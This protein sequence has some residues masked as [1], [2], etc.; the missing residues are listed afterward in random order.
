MNL[1]SYIQSWD[2]TIA[3]LFVNP[4]ITNFPMNLGIK[5]QN[6]FIPEPF[7]GD[8]NNCSLVIV[9]LNPGAGVCHSCFKQQ[10]IVGTLVNKVKSLGY[11]NA[12]KDFPYL[13]D[14]ETVGL[15]DWNDSPGRKWWKSK[16][17]W[18]KHMLNICVPSYD[19][20]YPIPDDYYPFAMEMFAWHTNSWPSKLNGKMKKDGSFG[21]TIESDVI[22]PLYEA[23]KKSKFKI[24]I[25]V[26]KPIG[27]I[28]GSFGTFN[29]I[30]SDKPINGNERQYDIYHDGDDCYII[31][32]WAPG[33]N[34]Y[35]SKDFETKEEM[36][37]QKYIRKQVIFNP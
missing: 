24:A 8:P 30:Y 37:F 31:N 6:D 5:I 1:S 19:S 15:T 34:T 23:I 18:I 26:G 3:S 11:S 13:R 4:L 29:M 2:Q 36:I 9:N 35:P 7:M 33:G 21:N 28:I 10:N 27:A 32:T 20:N 16:E 25:C 14:G 17:R 22:E 12:V